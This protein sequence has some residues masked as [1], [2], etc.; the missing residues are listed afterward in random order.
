MVVTFREAIG[1]GSPEL[2]ERYADQHLGD[3]DA[4][5]VTLAEQL[6]I[7]TIA[8]LERRHFSVVRSEYPSTRRFSTSSREDRRGSGPESRSDRLLSLPPSA[9]ALKRA[10]PSWTGG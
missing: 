3:A 8:I 9:G 6:G 10:S 2:T 4:D 1:D 7:T 5:L